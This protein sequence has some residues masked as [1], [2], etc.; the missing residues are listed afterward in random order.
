M[1]EWQHLPQPNVTFWWRDDYR[2]H[3]RWRWDVLP[4]GGHIR[5]VVLLVDDG[6]SLT[7]FCMIYFGL[8]ILEANLN[9]RIGPSF[10]TM[11]KDLLGK[12]CN[13]VNG[14]FI[15]FVLYILIYA[16]ISE[17]RSDSASYVCGN[18]AER[19]CARGGLYLCTAGGVCGMVEYKAVSRM[20][21]IV[22]S[23]KVII[24]LPELQQPAG[25]SHADH[26][27]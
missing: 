3:N 14:I 2:W 26:A 1:A 13:V 6:I 23:A 25:A 19:S 15:A 4:A 12:G 7:Q 17:K 5:G 8:S 18:V 20:T 21:A 27:V 24:F 22:L 16:Y 11:I 10:D 9:Y